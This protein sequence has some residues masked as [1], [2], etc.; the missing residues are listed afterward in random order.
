MAKVG[1]EVTAYIPV[2]AEY[3]IRITLTEEMLEEG[4]EGEVNI[5]LVMDEAYAEVPSDVC[6]H[7]S[8]WGQEWS[9]ACSGSEGEILYITDESGKEIYGDSS[10]KLGW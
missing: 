6:A 5:D 10:K 9:L 1:D 2:Y 8:G 3:A 7:C 4:D